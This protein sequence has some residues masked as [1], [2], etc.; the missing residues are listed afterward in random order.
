MKKNDLHV[1][2]MQQ[3]LSKKNTFST[4]TSQRNAKTGQVTGADKNSRVSDAENF[5]MNVIGAE[6]AM[7]EFMSARADDNVAKAEL[8]KQ[9]NN[10]GYATLKDIPNDIENKQSLNTLNVLFL[11]AG[12]ATDLITPGLAL[13]R[14][15]D[16]KDVKQVPSSK[17]N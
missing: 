2:R 5:A 9:I 12:I 8:E 11:G 16:G 6:A 1:K 4:E 7:K 14:T 3:L 17:Y 15:M 13:K 10:N